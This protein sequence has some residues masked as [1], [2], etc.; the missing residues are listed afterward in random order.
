MRDISS[1]EVFKKAHEL[2]LE[3]YKITKK[4][5]REELYGLSLQ[6]RR[7]SYSIPMNL[8]EGGV[9]SEAEFLKYVRISYGSS[10]ELSYQLILAYDLGYL[11]KEEYSTLEERLTEVQKMLYSLLKKGK[12]T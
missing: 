3:I 10:E 12:Q 5:P 8:K 11:K 7:S 4:F 6:M 1:Y 2:V 9:G